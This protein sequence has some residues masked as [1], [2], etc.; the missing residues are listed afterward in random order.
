MNVAWKTLLTVENPEDINLITV[1]NGGILLAS[2]DTMFWL[3]GIE[4]L[5]LETDSDLSPCISCS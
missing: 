4:R 5:S 2:N 1:L 3:A